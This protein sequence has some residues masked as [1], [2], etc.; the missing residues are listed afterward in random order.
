M[1]FNKLLILFYTFRNPDDL[2]T[3]GTQR[4]QKW[5][6]THRRREWRLQVCDAGRVPARWSKAGKLLRLSVPPV[7]HGEQLE[8]LTNRER[9]Y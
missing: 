9:S 4:R 3:H 2:D 5:G 1:Y 8:V 6:F 7:S